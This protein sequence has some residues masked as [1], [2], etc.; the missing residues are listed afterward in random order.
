MV[1]NESRGMQGTGTLLVA[2]SSGTCL[3]RVTCSGGG[4]RLETGHFFSSTCNVFSRVHLPS[5]DKLKPPKG[6]RPVAPS[7]R[8]YL[9]GISCSAGGQRNLSQPWPPVA[10]DV[11]SLNYNACCSVTDLV[12]AVGIGSF[13]PSRNRPDHRRHVLNTCLPVSCQSQG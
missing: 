9:S 13:K 6:T 4:I 11:R 10:V 1:G 5:T 7:S 2:P 12:M 8:T 3:S